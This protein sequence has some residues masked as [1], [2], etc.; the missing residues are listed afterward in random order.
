VPQEVEEVAIEEEEDIKDNKTMVAL[1]TTLES[2]VSEMLQLK[3]EVI[4][5]LLKN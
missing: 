1:F 3:S 4:G 5:Q 2:V